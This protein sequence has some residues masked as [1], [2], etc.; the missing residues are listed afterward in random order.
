MTTISYLKDHYIGKPWVFD[1]DLPS[2]IKAFFYTENW[3]KKSTWSIKTTFDFWEWPYF[4]SKHL[5]TETW[6]ES[7]S[8]S[9][10][11]PI[12]TPM[13]GIKP[14]VMEKHH[15]DKRDPIFLKT[16]FWKVW[17]IMILTQWS[18]SR[19]FSI[20]SSSKGVKLSIEILH[21]EIR[22]VVAEKSQCEQ[23]V[24]LKKMAFQNFW[25]GA[26]WRKTKNHRLFKLV[27]FH[28]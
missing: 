12:V 11:L 16:T 22:P 8:M 20:K 27:L 18:M 26:L 7:F 5:L 19:D 28:R 3:D 6:M 10:G 17:T 23:Q 14:A 21:D 9:V 24:K 2:I 15:F 13:K 1:W 25:P 4:D